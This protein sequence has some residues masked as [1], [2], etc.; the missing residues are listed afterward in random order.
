MELEFVNWLREHNQAP[1]DSRLQVGIG[2]DAAVLQLNDPRLV[3]SKD[4]LVDGVHFLASEHTPEQIGQKA[5]AVNLSDLAAMGARPR[6]AVLGL[7]IP[8]QLPND[9]DR[10]D[11][12]KRIV[13]GMLPFAKEFEC[14]IIGGDTSKS[15]GSLVISVTVF[16]ELVTSE[17]MLRSGAKP[18]DVIMVTGPLGG[19]LTGKHLDFQPRVNEAFQL[20]QTGLVH[21]AMDITDGLSLDLARMIEASVCGAVLEEA[22]IPVSS[23]AN[24]MAKT[25]GRPPLDHAL[26]DGEDFELLVTTD[27]QTADVWA[28]QAPCDCSLI[29]IGRIVANRGLFIQPPIGEIR[30]LKPKGYLH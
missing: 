18:D 21:A 14:P 13:K 12:A 23:A 29:P 8:A 9:H 24:E 26:S 3:V 2:D 4:L 19:S 15:R 7:A 25:S 17:P 5:L 1:L 6:G 30:Q 10:L 16:G 27:S 11:Y 28:E 22:S 20:V